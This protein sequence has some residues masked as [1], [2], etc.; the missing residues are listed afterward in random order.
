MSRRDL[1]AGPDRGQPAPSDADRV[2][3]FWAMVPVGAKYALRGWDEKAER[4]LRGL[5][6][7]VDTNP[8]HAR[9]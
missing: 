2:G 5:E 7:Q 8:Q 1:P 3:F 6:E 9:C 4:I